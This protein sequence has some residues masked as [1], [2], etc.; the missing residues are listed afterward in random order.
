ML[1]GGLGIVIAGILFFGWRKSH[2]RWKRVVAWIAGVWGGIS[3]AFYL[4]VGGLYLLGEHSD[5]TSRE[6][7][8]TPVEMPES[9]PTIT[10]ALSEPTAVPADTPTATERPTPTRTVV[11]T[12]TPT[13]PPGDL[14]L[15]ELFSDTDI[16]SEWDLARTGKC[17]VTI[18]E[19][20]LVASAA[21]PDCLASA[22]LPGLY[23]GIDLRVDAT[24][25][26]GSGW[27]TYGVLF[28]LTVAGE[29]Y[30]V[31]LVGGDGVAI[32]GEI[33][34]EDRDFGNAVSVL[35]SEQGSPNLVRLT[36][37]GDEWAVHVNG[38]CAGSG[39]TETVGRGQVALLGAT[40][41]DSASAKVA[42]DDLVIRIPDEDS[43][44]LLGCRPETYA[45][46]NAPV[47]QPT[48]PPTVPP[49]AGGNGTIYLTSETSA[50]AT[51]RLSVWGGPGEDFLLDSG[52]GHPA[53]RVVPAGEYGWEMHFGPEGRTG[54]TTI[55][56]PAAGSCSFTCYDEGVDWG[57]SP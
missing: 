12:E 2:V 54:A 14:L 10:E 9:M 55:Q 17:E 33:V 57:C 11:P 37:I 34:G 25:T 21:D 36:T 6:P 1:C 47:P 39:R 43:E 5:S 31:C 29:E 45:R 16:E 46:P 38:R 27:A 7:V 22:I 32:C 51:C 20:R 44:S 26:E 35:M 40:D 48:P 49:Q 8:A 24:V 18:R 4:G 53:S 13:R 3:I 19:G 42:F 23:S 50:E 28:G 52:P 15:A 56:L 41:S 30:V